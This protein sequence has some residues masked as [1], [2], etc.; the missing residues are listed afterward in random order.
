MNGVKYFA[1]TNCFIYLLEENPLLLTF[2]EE[3]WAFSY[4]TEI[5]ILSKK[6][7]NNDEE[8]LIRSMLSTSYKLDHNQQ[9]SELAIQLKRKN[10]IKL[11]DA[12]IAASAQFLRLP[13]L[14]A[15]QGF[16][17][18]KSIDCIILNL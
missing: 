18:I 8:H 5:E 3:V 15:D 16:S 12:I 17:K 11:P 4:I 7:I 9:I 14:T 6:D 10:N 2:A 13:L 1:D